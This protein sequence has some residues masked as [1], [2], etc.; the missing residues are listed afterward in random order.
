MTNACTK[1]ALDV[2]AGKEPGGPYVRWACERHIGDCAR[3]AAGESL[4]WFDSAAAE[5]IR[6]FAGELVQFTGVHKGQRLE[7]LPWQSFCFGSIYGWKRKSDGLRRFRTAYIQVPRKN[8]KSTMA[9]VPALY[10]LTCEG[11][12]GAQIYSLATKETQAKIVWEMA[13]HITAKTPGLKSR[14]RS[15]YNQISNLKDLATFFRPLG[16]NSEKLD[17]LNPH[18]AICDELHAWPDRMLFDVMEDG[19]GS[20]AQPLML[21]ITTAGYDQEGI[22]YQ[23]RDHCVSVLDPENTEWQD[24]SLFAYVAELGADDVARVQGDTKEL[25]NRELWYRVNPSLGT[26]K[27]VD[28]ME[29]QV[30]DAIAKPSKRNAV[31]NKQFNIWTQA[32]VAWLDRDAWDACANPALTM[33]SMRNEQCIAA[34]DLAKVNDLSS[35]AYLFPPNTGKGIDR[36]RLITRCWVPEDD[37]RGRSKNDAPYDVWAQEGWIL[38][39]PGDCTDYDYIRRDIN[40]SAGIVSI[41]HLVF[42]R[43][44]ANELVQHLQQDGLPV[45]SYGQGYA[46]MGSPTSELERLILSRGIEHD[47]NR[48]MRWQIGHVIVTSDSSGNLKPDKMKSKKKIDS[49]V[50]TVMALG[51]AMTSE[52]L[53]SVYETRGIRSL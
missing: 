28:Y 10:A 19:M 20:R 29:Q 9:T 21:I 48:V 22:C 5:K 42:D 16:A 6:A 41:G 52:P 33:E 24:D 32:Q 13:K 15:H 27:R 53:E 26:A 17:G 44:F 11:E 14:L 3:S 2:I 4:F 46:A 38:T 35:A 25:R 23:T 43:H 47:G 31:L 45:M 7:L 12:A 34:L 39:T 51:V 37:L 50:A 30:A 8:G 18:L 40:E 36:Y 1:Y 49:I